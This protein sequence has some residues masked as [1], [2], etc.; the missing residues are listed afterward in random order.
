MG[1]RNDLNLCG[2]KML[3]AMPQHCVVA[4]PGGE[5]FMKDL[6]LRTLM[7]QLT[8]F[9]A[10]LVLLTPLANSQEL[11]EIVVTAQKREQNLQEVPISITAITGDQLRELRITTTDGVV[12]H[13]PGLTMFS[14]LAADNTPNFSLRGVSGA[15]ITSV[16][17]APIAVYTDEIYYGTQFGAIS[18]L[19]DLE[20][21]EALRGPQGTLFGRNATGGLLHFVTNKPVIGETEGYVQLG[22]GSHNEVHLEG[23]YN[24]ALGDEWALRISGSRHTYDGYVKNRFPDVADLNDTDRIAGRIQLG[25]EGDRSRFTLNFHTAEDDSRVGAW[26][27]VG[28][29]IVDA[30]GNVITP[31]L[32]PTGQTVVASNGQSL[33]F[34]PA[35]VDAATFQ[36]NNPDG[37]TGEAFTAYAESLAI[38][39]VDTRRAPNNPINFGL[40][41]GDYLDTDGDPWAGEYNYAAPLNISNTGGWARYEF[42]INEGMT[43]VALGG[44]E[45]FDQL[46]LE[47]T[48]LSPIDDIRAYFGGTNEQSSLEFRLEGSNDT[49]SNY[50]FGM[51]FY[52]RDV[53]D[54]AGPNVVLPTLIDN[55]GINPPQSLR[56]N[57]NTESMAA[58]GQ[59]DF[60]LT[61]RLTLTAG[62]RFTDEE[63]TL[64]SS[65]G[66]VDFCLFANVD[67]ATCAAARQTTFLAEIP[68]SDQG[69]IIDI[70]AFQLA[71]PTPTNSFD[72][73]SPQPAGPPL[74]YVDPNYA[75]STESL[76]DSF[77]TGVLKL[78]YA[79]NDNSMIYGSYSQGSKSGGFN[80]NPDAVSVLGTN[81]Y[82]REQLN[83][84]EVGYR[85]EFADG[86]VRLNGTLFDYDYEDFQA[87]Q[88][89]APGI[90]GTINTD[91]EITGA[92]IEFLAALSDNWL[93]SVNTAHIFDSSVDNITDA[94][95]LTRTRDMKQ[96][97]ELQFNAYLQFTTEA[98]GGEFSAQVDYAY[99]D[100]Y[101]SFLDN[102]GGGQ[103]PSYDKM[104]ASATWVS[105]DDK[106][107]VRGNI[108]NLM[109][110]EILISAF[111]FSAGS[112]YV[113]ELYQAP[114]WFSVSF[115]VNF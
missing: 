10:A 89:L 12:E 100:Q 36:L 19:Y 33:Q 112:A 96:A 65:S 70:E 92:E 97:P 18:Q 41:G 64:T 30:S 43:F 53:K 1:M 90:A 105:A 74:N 57:G 98:F 49:L 62:L 38:Q 115:G 83:S 9:A 37:L 76:T 54:D 102:L 8:G 77:T 81:I 51:Y 55:V 28:A 31:A 45:T 106:W 50:V 56:R 21:Y 22:L 44:Y 2:T 39:G 26:Q 111:D 93:L 79:L 69:V 86:R 87:R 3:A 66:N 40:F 25:Y 114:R 16:T 48:D 113:Q 24:F 23:A 35:D 95:G 107:Y 68:L 78:A 94:L 72:F 110:E 6:N 11:E 13:T 58:F 47:D 104:G 61:D 29:E 46:Y 101:F 15:D 84:L 91:A 32:D 60:A 73:I 80:D 63:T 67:Q 71:A 108:T 75:Q 109:D 7:G 5:D 27:I 52:D 82:A 88:F 59:I 99:S 42:D 103:V 20:R 14:P 17:E 4:Y 85:G 34:N